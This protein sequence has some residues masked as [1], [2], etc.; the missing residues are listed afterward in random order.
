MPVRFGKS[1]PSD[2]WGKLVNEN[3]ALEE[4][5]RFYRIERAEVN[6]RRFGRQLLAQSVWIDSE[7]QFLELIDKTREAELFK[8]NLNL[9]RELCPAL[10]PLLAL[11]PNLMDEAGQIWPD[12][13]KVCCYFKSNP[14]PGL[15]ARQLPIAVDT[16]F[17]GRNEPLLSQLLGCFQGETTGCDSANF[18][19]RFGL[20]VDECLIRIRF[21]DP[22]LQS[23]YSPDFDQIA[24]LLSHLT[25]LQLAGITVLIVE[26][27]MNFLTLPPL[28]NTLAIYGEGNK[29]ELLSCL[30]WLQDC[31]A[32]YWGDIDSHG[33]HMLARLRA[34]FSHVSSIFMDNATLDS[35]FHFTV[36]AKP[37]TYERSDELT[38]QEKEAYQRVTSK[39]ILLEQEKIPYQVVVDKLT[40]LCH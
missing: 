8:R 32:I 21:L 25:N 20:L 5:S 10:E 19:T 27:K 9:T 2:T 16:K 39:Q 35:W 13:L 29:V 33:F 18:N 11:R 15:Y 4:G 22:E 30:H 40:S 26:N 31:R 37:A 38:N 28:R 17:I 24:I 7:S 12:V 3:K 1:K 6:T 14:R 34:T 23:R 36:K